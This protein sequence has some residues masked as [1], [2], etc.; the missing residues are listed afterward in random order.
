MIEVRK[1]SRRYRQGE[2][3]VWA[4]HG[5]DLRIQDREFVAIVGESG[6]GKSTLLHLLGGLDK[7]DEG[8]ILVDGWSLVSATDRELTQYRRT[9][10]GIVFQFFNLLPTLNVLENVCL[11]LQLQG[12]KEKEVRQRAL[13]LLEMVGLQHRARH[14]VHQL[15]GG[16]MQRAAIARALIHRPKLLLADEPTG[17]LDAENAERVM[18]AFRWIGEQGLTTLLIATHSR[19][20]AGAA[21]RVIRLATGKVAAP[22]VSSEK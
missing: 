10:L 22:E 19:A 12:Q 6:S 13:E 20:V 21:H 17:N 11:P 4:L 2:S 9:R 16:E 15:S 5:V 7:P 14:F 8:E 3:P 1:V 18:E